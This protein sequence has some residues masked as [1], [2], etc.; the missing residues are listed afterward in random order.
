[1]KI[2]AIG[3]IHGLDIWK[4]IIEANLDADLFIFLADYFDSFDES[5]TPTIQINNYLEIINFKKENMDKCILLIGNHD[6]HYMSG[7]IGAYGGFN[8]TT[9]TN[10]H[11][12]LMEHLRE[13]LLQVAYEH[14]NYLFTHAGVSNTW[15]EENIINN[16]HLDNT[17]DSINDLFIYTPNKFNFLYSPLDRSNDGNSKENGPLWIRPESLVKDLYSSYIQVVG[18]THYTYVNIIDEKLIVVDS[19]PYKY[20]VIDTDSGDL[21]IR[22]V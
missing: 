16:V 22:N 5:L 12:L 17:I 15:F 7:C 11:S 18:H 14:S 6:F 13:N 19:L 2:V 21:C 1:M 4:K 8:M 20:L 9:Y 3:D 10:V